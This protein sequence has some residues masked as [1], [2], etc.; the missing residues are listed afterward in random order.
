MGGPWQLPAR[1]I[2]V[3]ADECGKTSLFNRVV[4][5]VL[6]ENYT[7]V[8]GYVGFAENWAEVWGS[9][10]GFRLE[11]TSYIFPPT[12]SQGVALYIVCCCADRPLSRHFARTCIASLRESFRAKKERTRFLLHCGKS[13]IHLTTQ[14]LLAL[15][16]ELQ[17]DGCVET[18]S[19]T[20]QGINNL[21][22]AI[23]QLLA[24]EPAEERR[25]CLVC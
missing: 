21:V 12:S 4:F 1:V 17:V 10:G 14:H 23:F 16:V 8:C 24:S 13:D 9:S 2:I 15:A 20:G 25:A 3:G 6:D 11:D 18:S 7:R 19:L 22:R 5:D